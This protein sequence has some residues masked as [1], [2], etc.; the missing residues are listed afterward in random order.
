MGY[1]PGK[2][3]STILVLIPMFLGPSDA[4]GHLSDMLKNLHCRRLFLFKIRESASRF[5]PPLVAVGDT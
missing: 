1:V 2:N 4:V 3:A 5:D